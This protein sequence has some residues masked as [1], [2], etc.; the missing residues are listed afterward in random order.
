MAPP[1]LPV[2]RSS[3]GEKDKLGRLVTPNDS[4]PGLAEP[5]LAD[6]S[7][8]VTRYGL[9]IAF[10]ALLLA[11]GTTLC[12]YSLGLATTLSALTTL[13]LLFMVSPLS[14]HIPRYSLC[15]ASDPSSELD[16]PLLHIEKAQSCG[17]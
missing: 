6:V 4:K 13:G 14:T 9:C 17:C 1:I 15:H 8:A 3:D 16:S 11:G 12:L 2:N 7:H 5:H 10:A